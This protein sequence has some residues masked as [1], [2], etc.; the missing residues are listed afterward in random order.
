MFFISKY[1]RKKMQKSKGMHL[2]TSQSCLYSLAIRFCAAITASS[3]CV[4]ITIQN[5][6][7]LAVKQINKHEAKWPL[8]AFC[9]FQRQILHSNSANNGS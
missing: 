4:I 8:I 1:E 2:N 5:Q 3:C 6:N 7:I 9:N